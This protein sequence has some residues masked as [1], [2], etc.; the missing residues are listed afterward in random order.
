ML[1]FLIPIPLLSYF[2]LNVL[3]KI[4]EHYLIP[5]FSYNLLRHN[6]LLILLSIKLGIL[7]SSHQLLLMSSRLV[8]LNFR[9]VFLDKLIMWIIIPRC[10][11]LLRN[12]F[13]LIING[14][15]RQLNFMIPLDSKEL[16]EIR[17]I[18]SVHFPLE[19]AI[20]T[21]QFESILL[22]FPCF[23]KSVLNSKL[24]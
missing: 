12:I 13:F 10:W 4:T 24:P 20:C 1:Q 22:F 3:H 14:Q 16:N 15:L 9:E 23:G 19:M 2:F 11:I 17:F 6:T 7:W 21:K 8:E 18:Q 5:L